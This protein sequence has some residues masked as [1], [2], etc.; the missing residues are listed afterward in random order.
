MVSHEVVLGS[1]DAYADG[2]LPDAQ[3]AGIAAHLETCTECRESLR[4][5]HGFDHIL[6][7]LPAIP[8]V[9]F[10]QFWSSLEPRLLGHAPTRP[11]LFRP[12]RLAAGFALAVL[13]SLVGVVALASDGVMP[14]SPLYA[15]K[16]FRQGVQVKLADA[17]DRPR[18][19]LSLGKQ[20]LDEAAQ[21]VKRKRPELA[22]AS[23]HDVRTLLSDAAP[24]LKNTRAAQSDAAGV[25]ST[26]TEIQTGLTAVSGAV[27][28][29][30]VD[31]T[32]GA[33]Q[34]A[35]EDAEH[36]ATQ[37]EAPSPAEPGEPAA[38]E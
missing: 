29:D 16:H 7:D 4:Q 35:V 23:L 32:D 19:E 22:V 36:A 11:P 15:V 33:V 14:D 6:T 18:L 3:R 34:S 1:L 38:S 26:L 31:A 25:K 8:S 13:A 12:A 5:I 20:R 21:M 17:H 37:V 9:P 28:A 24:R 30:G 10:S 2:S 27:V